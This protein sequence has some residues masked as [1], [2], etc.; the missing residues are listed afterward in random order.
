[1]N[2]NILAVLIQEGSRLASEILRHKNPGSQ[3]NEVSLEQFLTESDAR[4]EP[5]FKSQSEPLKIETKQPI[6][7]SPQPVSAIQINVTE[8]KQSPV[9]NK[10]SA[11][12]NK[13]SAIATGCVPCALGHVGTCTGLLNESIRFS[14]SP[15][16]L[17]SPEVID[18]VGMCLDELNAMERVD[19]RP[20]MTSQLTGWEKELVDKTLT[21]SRNLR[22]RLENLQSIEDLEQA[23]AI[24]QEKRK[25]IGRGWF[26]NKLTNLSVEDKAEIQKRVMA[27]IE[28]LANTDTEES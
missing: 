4:F 12:E 28:E 3:S 13:A 11:I 7:V 2:T 8:Q 14:H 10:A 16:G 1:M 17:A 5:Y 20:E 27:K 9:E 24:T 21:E 26:Q 6:K 19:L 22:H 23:A 15:D 18:R 25:E